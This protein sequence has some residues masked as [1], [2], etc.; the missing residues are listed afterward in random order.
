MLRK[1][2]IAFLIATALSGCDQNVTATIYVRDLQDLLSQPTNGKTV[3]VTMELEVLAPG[4][5]DKCDKPEIQQMV[6]VVASYFDSATLVG[7]EQVKGAM[8][9]TLRIKS[10]TMM[11]I[12][13]TGANG[14]DSKQLIK[15]AVTRP[16]NGVATLFVVFNKSAY[17][18]LNERIRAINMMAHLKTDE[19]HITVVLDNDTREPFKWASGSGNWYDGRPQAI[20]RQETLAPRGSTAMKL[21]DVNM[22]VLTIDQ[23]FA[24]AAFPSPP[25]E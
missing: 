4:L 5:R 14:F 13:A 19:A 21:G 2:G 18:E 1:F 8:Y 17:D 11:E 24:L 12:Q 23:N 3:P 9:D 20:V 10:G 22:A 7:C 16:D 25:T 6:S 15:F